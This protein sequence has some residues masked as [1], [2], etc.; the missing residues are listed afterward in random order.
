MRP[1]S[2]ILLML[3]LGCGL[4][5]SIG[6]TQ[7]MANRGD[8][9]VATADTAPI[10]V[11]MDNIPQWS[12]ITAHR[13]RIENWPKDKVPEDALSNIED[14]EGRRTKT[15]I[16]A[17]DPIR[18][19]KLFDHGANE[20]GATMMIPEGLRAVPVKVDSV[21]GGSGLIV[22]GDRVDVAVTIQPDTKKGIAEPTTKTFLQDIK[23][24]AVN[25]QFQVDP[26]ED[27]KSISAKTVSLLV[28]PEQA[29]MLMLAADSG[30]IQLVLRSPDESANAKVAAVTL[31]QVLEAAE[32]ADREQEELV[33]EDKPQAE[34]Q[35]SGLAERFKDFLDKQGAQLAAAAKT[36]QPLPRMEEDRWTVRLIRAADVER[37][38]LQKD[39]DGWK[40]TGGFTSA[41]PAG[42]SGPPGGIPNIPNIPNMP[43]LT[44]IPDIEIPTVDI[45]PPKLPGWM[46]G[47]DD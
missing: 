11:A 42:G 22:P 43:E 25:D 30:K 7:V 13:V 1:K 8:G 36:A 23:V 21:S 38:V 10:L 35:L 16:Y 28:T 6:I 20:H 37:V 40:P 33:E 31:R 46:A 18:E 27:D 39:E 45:T 12:L 24:F 32:K 29:Q 47:G 34:S 44:N 3:A 5:A 19:A 26:D 4:V 17:G 41:A 9:A 15:L 14:A 2:L